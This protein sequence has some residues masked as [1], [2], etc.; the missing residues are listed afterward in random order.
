MLEMIRQLWPWYV[1]G[2]LIGI[3]VLLLLV[4]RKTNSL[5]KM[6]LI[7]QVTCLLL[8]GFVITLFPVTGV[9]ASL[10]H[11]HTGKQDAIRLMTTDQPVLPVFSMVNKADEEV[12]LSAFKGKKVF[13]NIWATWC[14]PCRAELSSIQNLLQQTDTSKVKFVMLSVDKEFETAKKYM[15]KKFPLL[16]MYYPNEDLPPL[17]SVPGIPAT[18]IF[19]EKG[20]LLKAIM[21][22][23]NFNTKAYL[24]LLR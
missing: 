19:N 1:A 4:A 12:D 18:F 16:P 10:N 8:I 24:T 5:I 21:G 11:S 14:L 23:E 20:E 22:R 9:F 6:R 15:E 13:V 7:K 2:L 17:F 3:M